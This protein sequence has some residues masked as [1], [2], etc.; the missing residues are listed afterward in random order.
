MLLVQLSLPSD[1]VTQITLHLSTL[2]H[3]MYMHMVLICTNFSNHKNEYSYGRHFVHTLVL[4]VAL[5]NGLVCFH[6]HC[7]HTELCLL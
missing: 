1:C 2:L 7:S 5:S 4:C 6:F 3:V